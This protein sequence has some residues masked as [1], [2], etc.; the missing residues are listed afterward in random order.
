MGNMSVSCCIAYNRLVLLETPDSYNLNAKGQHLV[1]YA[2]KATIYVFIY[3]LYYALCLRT[4]HIPYL[5]VFNLVLDY[6][7]ADKAAN[8]RRQ[9]FR[10]IGTVDVQNVNL[11]V[12]TTHHIQWPITSFLSSLSTLKMMKRVP[13][14]ACLNRITPTICTMYAQ[15]GHS[16]CLRFWLLRSEDMAIPFQSP[17]KR[18]NLLTAA[19][20]KRPP[21]RFMCTRI[22][23]LCCPGMRNPPCVFWWHVRVCMRV[24]FSCTGVFKKEIMS[25][26]CLRVIS[27]C[28]YVCVNGGCVFWSRW[29]FSEIAH[30]GRVLTTNRSWAK[31]K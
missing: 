31:R 11:R 4:F 18:P 27:E 30:A 21:F 6:S 28:A 26:V 12:L 8:L 20:S 1:M 25:C 14:H 5:V 29:E 7:M 24:L 19:T 13:G 15:F 23:C 17:H 3:L 9:I 2:L 10:R 22:S 16:N